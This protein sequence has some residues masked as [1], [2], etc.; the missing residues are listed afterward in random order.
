MQRSGR[1]GRHVI[2]VAG[3][4]KTTTRALDTG[5][6]LIDGVKRTSCKRYSGNVFI[7]VA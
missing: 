3:Q 2:A 7:R 4:T 1:R 6:F 5:L